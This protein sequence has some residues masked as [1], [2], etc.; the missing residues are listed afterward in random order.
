MFLNTLPHKNTHC[1]AVLAEGTFPGYRLIS[2]S[3]LCSSA[4]CM[5]ERQ[6]DTHSHTFTHTHQN[7]SPDPE[8]LSREVSAT[9]VAISVL[10]IGSVLT[11]YKEDTFSARA[12]HQCQEKRKILSHY[13]RLPHFHKQKILF[14]KKNNI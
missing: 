12:P 10:L 3:S 13:I 4:V 7:V 1:N 5:R 11:A 6:S 14:W 2:Q 9:E 8:K